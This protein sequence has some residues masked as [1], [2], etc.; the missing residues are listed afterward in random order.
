MDQKLGDEEVKGDVRGH[1]APV[2]YTSTYNSPL[3]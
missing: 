2:V 1:S 3:E